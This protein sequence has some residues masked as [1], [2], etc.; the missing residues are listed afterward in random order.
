M[1]S[2]F[3]SID[4]DEVVI[5]TQSVDEHIGMDSMTQG[6]SDCST[7]TLFRQLNTVT[8]R[9]DLNV[10]ANRTQSTAGDSI[11]SQIVECV[12]VADKDEEL[13]NTT[14]ISCEKGHRYVASSEI[15][16]SLLASLESG[17]VDT[18]RKSPQYDDAV[19]PIPILSPTPTNPLLLK[20]ALSAVK[21]Y[22]VPKF[23]NLL[24]SNGFDPNDPPLLSPTSDIL[25]AANASARSSFAVEDKNLVAPPSPP[26]VPLAVAVVPHS[27]P[28]LMTK[29][30]KI[31]TTLQHLDLDSIRRPT[32]GVVRMG[33][34]FKLDTAS[35]EHGEEAW[36]SQF[37]TVDVSS[38]LFIHFAEING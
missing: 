15:S 29:Y 16:E 36:M 3:G 31:I 12:I 1:A 32:D 5:P 38:G 19:D 34:L 33:Y 37:V 14:Q 2:L 30:C 20:A 9:E 7:S 23:K 27:P 18:P 26:S 17:S 22:K 11:A 24:N 25:A 8:V 10:E 13:H 4:D 6:M 28:A 35:K 21:P